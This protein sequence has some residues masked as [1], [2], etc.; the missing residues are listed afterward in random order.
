MASWTSAL[1]STPALLALTLL[2]S[3]AAPQPAGAQASRE[4]PSFGVAGGWGAAV[5]RP[6][7]AF[8]PVN[9]VFLV[10]S[11]NRTHG[12]FVTADGGPLGTQFYI[13]T[14]GAHNQTAK[15]AYSPDLGGFLVAW[16]DTRVNPNAYQIWGRLVKF[17]AGGAPDYVGADF[18]IAAPA[19]GGNAELGIDIGYATG[20]KRFLVAYNQIQRGEVLAQMVGNDGVLVGG[21]VDVTLDNHSQAEPSVS[22]DPVGDQ[23]LV[24]FRHWYEPAGPGAV[25]VRTVSAA[26]GA[27]GTTHEVARAISCY[28]PQIER[29]SSTGQFL[30]A[31]YT[32]PHVYGRLLGADGAPA[33]DIKTLVFNYTTYDALGL[34]YNPQTDTYLTVTHGRLKEDV[35]AQISAA[36]VPDVE[37]EVTGTGA[38]NGSFNPRLAANPNRKEWMVVTSRDFGMVYGQR[39]STLNTNP[40]PPGTPTPTDNPP[41]TPTTI[42]LSEAAAPNQSWFLAEGAASPTPGGFSTYYLIANEND[43]PVTVKAYYSSDDGRLLTKTYT[44]AAG[45]RHTLDLRVEAGPGAFA[46]VFQSQTPAA[47]VFVER[48]M[49]WGSSFEG[50]TGAT[51]VK[52]LGSRWIFA[53]GSRGGEYFANFFLLFNP[54]QAAAPT[55]ARFFL[56]SGQ[57]IH[58]TY[59][60]PAQ[61]RLTIDANQIPELAGQDFSTMFETPS[62]SPIVAER[63]MYWGPNW[64]GGTAA[65]G[66][67]AASH[68]WHFAEGA[69]AANFE[70]FYLLLNAGATAISVRG[71]FML[72]DGTTHVRTY[73][74]P[75]FARHTVYVNGELGIVGGFSAS[76]DAE[77]GTPLVVE[78]SIYWGA[79]RVDGTST[80]GVTSPALE[81]HLP[82]GTAGGRFDT[83]MLISNP[84]P[85]AVTAD[86]TLFVEGVGKFTAPPSM[87]P[88]L[89]PFSRK[90]IYM[91]AFLSELGTLEGFALAGRSFSTKVRVIE[92][93][94]PIVVEHAIYWQFD[95]P[96]YWRA[97]SGGFGIAR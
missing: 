61:G 70:T 48:S 28:M 19:I 86:V 12:R 5:R 30:V 8:D 80:I 13:P 66:V 34:R 26:S 65:V 57:V 78:R 58:K 33:G 6:D 55:E 47:D 45:S 49:Y 54:L 63:A 41:P 23:F 52:D 97:G 38:L 94:P 84:N 81:W 4:G 73:T 42:D 64:M 77:T 82:E 27:L 18:L 93:G 36:A 46:A 17:G 67:N 39:V 56:P 50:S 69:T 75:G 7:A 68:V 92:A 24:A 51:G 11:G 15:A 10:V 32:Q 20:S 9:N 37:F 90:T 22:Y 59:I 25:W 91:N 53:E 44:V 43:V 60:V 95:G 21:V 40:N 87:R 14:N 89:P 3:L 85:V 88:T 62:E 83:F 2:A 74:I 29:N 96:N 31:W 1:R 76:F 79:G 71:T 16:F 72:E 35:A